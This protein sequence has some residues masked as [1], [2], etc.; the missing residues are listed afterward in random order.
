MKSWMRFGL[1][2]VFLNLLGIRCDFDCI[3]FKRFKFGRVFFF[4]FKKS[5]FG[6]FVPTFLCFHHQNSKGH[7]FRHNF[8]CNFIHLYDSFYIHIQ[9]LS[10]YAFYLNWRRHVFPKFSMA[11]LIAK[12]SVNFG[13]NGFS[14]TFA[15]VPSRAF[16]SE[17][18][19]LFTG[20]ESILFSKNNF[21]TGSHDIIHI[22][23]N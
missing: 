14:S 22:F 19:A 9:F 4:F 1:K 16:F 11:L 2:N 3:L 15:F 7:H 12:V 20:P 17:S 5:V 21:K 18:R 8:N 13:Y 6:V 10:S 23:K